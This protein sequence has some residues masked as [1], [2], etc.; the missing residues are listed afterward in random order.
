MKRGGS[1]NRGELWVNVAKMHKRGG[2]KG[3]GGVKKKLGGTIKSVQ[4]VIKNRIQSTQSEAG[5][6]R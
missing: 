1:W 4:P 2:V 3:Q 5:A 6:W